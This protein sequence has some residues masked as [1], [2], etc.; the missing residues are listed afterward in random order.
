M[1]RSGCG[2]A[3][4]AQRASPPRAAR[5][6]IAPIARSMRFSRCPFPCSAWGSA[7]R[8]ELSLLSPQGR[9]ASKGKR[10]GCA[11]PQGGATA[12]TPVKARVF[13]PAA[14]RAAAAQRSAGAMASHGPGALMPR[15]GGE[16]AAA[17]SR[18]CLVWEREATP[19]APGGKKPVG[20][21]T[22]TALA[23]R[24]RPQPGGS[25]AENRDA[26]RRRGHAVGR[27]RERPASSV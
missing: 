5:R 6:A 1:S 3:H 25:R 10:E 12:E 9:D 27:H 22:T 24:R 20:S 11:I 23:H 4:H 15:Q 2:E 17:R 26:V 7:R 8:R 16:R 14:R 19:P 13:S 21:S 18:I